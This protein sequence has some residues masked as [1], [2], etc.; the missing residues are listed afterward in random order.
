[1]EVAVCRQEVDPGTLL[2]RSPLRIRLAVGPGDGDIW[3]DDLAL[4]LVAPRLR[5]S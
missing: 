3:I 5:A 2:A 1:M 4:L